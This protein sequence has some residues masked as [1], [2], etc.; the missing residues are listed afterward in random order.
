[1][2]I[3]AIGIYGDAYDEPTVFGGWINPN[4]VWIVMRVLAGGR[5]AAC[6]RWSLARVVLL[7]TR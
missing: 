6:F 5:C 1:M 2:N 4:L 3:I 7:T